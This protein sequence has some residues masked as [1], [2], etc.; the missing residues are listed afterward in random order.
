MF[1]EPFRFRGLLDPLAHGGFLKV[2]PDGKKSLLEQSLRDVE[3][4]TS[5]AML[6]S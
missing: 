5:I 1:I 3:D 2:S 6:A 4:E